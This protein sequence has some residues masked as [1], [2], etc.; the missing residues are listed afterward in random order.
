MAQGI[1][2]EDGPLQGR[3]EMPPEGCQGHTLN[4]NFC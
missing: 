2:P 1:L 4:F 3:S